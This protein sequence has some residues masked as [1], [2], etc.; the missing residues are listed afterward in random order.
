MIPDARTPDTHIITDTHV[1]SLA[2]LHAKRNGWH[3]IAEV[4]VKILTRSNDI[5]HPLHSL[6]IAALPG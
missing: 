6:F 3:Q 1:L 2:E 4:R 5:F